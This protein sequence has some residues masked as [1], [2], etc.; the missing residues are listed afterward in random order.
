[1][2]RL[3]DCLK[4]AVKRGGL[5]KDEL[6]TFKEEALGTAIQ[7]I[8]SSGKELSDLDKQNIVT[9]AN[10]S[11]ATQFIDNQ[12]SELI[13]INEVINTKPEVA[14]KLEQAKA[15]R[16]KNEQEQ[17]AKAEEKQKQKAGDRR[18]EVIQIRLAKLS[19]IKNPTEKEQKEIVDL[20]NEYLDAIKKKPSTSEIGTKKVNTEVSEEEEYEEDYEDWKVTPNLKPNT[21]GLEVEESLADLEQFTKDL[22]S[23]IKETTAPKLPSDK[24]FNEMFETEV[25]DKDGAKA[26][27]LSTQIFKINTLFSKN[28]YAAFL[29]RLKRKDTVDNRLAFR[30]HMMKYITALKEGKA[31]EFIRLDYAPQSE[32]R[33]PRFPGR[34][35]HKTTMYGAGKVFVANIIG[36]VGHY[37]NLSRKQRE[38]LTQIREAS[39][40]EGTKPP[41]SFA[42]YVA[43]QLKFTGVE[44]KDLDSAD[45]AKLSREYKKLQRDYRKTATQLP[46]IS[47][48]KLS[49]AEQAVEDARSKIIRLVKAGKLKQSQVK[50]AMAKQIYNNVKARAEKTSLEFEEGY[51]ESQLKQAQEYYKNSEEIIYVGKKELENKTFSEMT[52]KEQDAY[53]HYKMLEEGSENLPAGA[54]Y[55]NSGFITRSNGTERLASTPF[56]DK[57]R[58]A[59]MPKESQFTSDRLGPYVYAALASKGLIKAVKIN[60]IERWVPTEYGAEGILNIKDRISMKPETSQ[61]SAP[62][63][64]KGTSTKKK[65]K[66]NKQA[67]N[68]SKKIK[69]VLEDW[70]KQKGDKFVKSAH[71]DRPFGNQGAATRA[72]NQLAESDKFEVVKFTNGHVVRLKEI[73]T[74]T[75][76]ADETEILVQRVNE[77]L[78]I[79]YDEYQKNY[80]VIDETEATE[81]LTSGLEGKKLTKQQIADI[82]AFKKNHPDV[83]LSTFK[84]KK[85]GGFYFDG[86]IYLIKENLKTEADVIAVFLHEGG[87]LLV[88]KDPRFRVLYAQI[89]K[90]FHKK[91]KTDPTLKRIYAEVK[92]VYLQEDWVEETIMHYVQ[93]QAN[94]NKP[95]Y[96]ELISKL[97]VWIAIRFNKAIK[98]DG[99]DLG[100]IIRYHIQ[101]RMNKKVA[102]SKVR[103]EV[104]DPAI[105]NM[106]TA[107]EGTNKEKKMLQ[108]ARVAAK[109][110]KDP[111]TQVGAVI[112]DEDGK[113]ISSGINVLPK[114]MDSKIYK[115]KETKYEHIIHSEV[116]AISKAL[117]SGK[118]LVGST[119]SVYPLPP[120]QKCM[121]RIADAGISKVIVQI[122]ENSAALK[123]WQRSIMEAMSIA[124]KNNIE[125]VTL[126]EL[127]AKDVITAEMAKMTF[128]GVNTQNPTAI[129]SLATAKQMGKDGK[130]QRYI[131][132]NTGWF[133]GPQD[134]MPRFEINDD[135][136]EVKQT[137]GITSVADF[138]QHDE[139]FASYPWIKDI[140]LDFVINPDIDKR[141]TYGLT[142]PNFKDAKKG[143][144]AGNY[145]FDIEIEAPNINEAVTA[146]LHE[147]QHTIQLE[148]GFGRGGVRERETL[149]TP[150]ERRLSSG[151]VKTIREAKALVRQKTR[152]LKPKLSQEDYAQVLSA[153]ELAQLGVAQ[154]IMAKFDNPT[155]LYNR[156]KKLVG[157]IEAEDVEARYKNAAKGMPALQ[158]PSLVSYLSYDYA[159]RTVLKKT[160]LKEVKFSMADSFKSVIDSFI[161]SK[162]PAKANAAKLINDI[163]YPNI[164]KDRQTTSNV[165]RIFSSSEHVLVKDETSERVLE[166]ALNEESVRHEKQ[167]YILGDYL[168][169][170]RGIEHKLGRRFWTSVTGKNKS[171]QKFMKALEEKV[172]EY[173]V[174]V[175]ATGKGWRVKA[176]QEK[177]AMDDIELDG[178][179]PDRKVTHYVVIKPNGKQVARKFTDKKVAL[180]VAHGLEY[181]YLIKQGYSKDAALWIKKSRELTDRAFTVLI[182]DLERGIKDAKLHGI[183]PNRRIESKDGKIKSISLTQAAIEMG[184]LQGTYFPRERP[185]KEY[186]VV[187]TKGK[188][189]EP[190][191]KQDRKN[192]S[193]FYTTND[194]SF[195]VTNWA[196]EQLR[197]ATPAAIYARKMRVAGWTTE[198]EII[199]TPTDMIFDMPKL[200]ASMSTILGKAA[201]E[202]GKVTK[203][204]TN[205]A[206]QNMFDQITTNINQLFATRS[207]MAT[208]AARQK[209]LWTGYETEANK[210]LLSY[211]QRTAAAEA[212]KIT[213]RSMVLAFTGRDKSFNKWAETQVP[214][215]ATEENYRAFAQDRAI[216]PVKQKKLWEDTQTFISH[217]LKPNNTTANVIGVFKTLAVLKYLGWRVS[218]PAV[219]MTNM[220]TGVIGTMSAKTDIG[221]INSWKLV[222]HAADTYFRYRLELMQKTGKAKR[223]PST[224]VTTEE[225][226]VYDYVSSK[227]WDSPLYN[228]E[229]AAAMDNMGGKIFNS[230]IKHAMWMFGQSEKAN[231]AMTIKASFDA[232]RRSKADTYTRMNKA[233]SNSKTPE[234]KQDAFEKI[235][236]EAKRISDNAHGS[237]GKASKPWLIQ[238]YK[239]LDVPYTF[240][241]FTHNYM[242]NMYN[243]GFNDKQ[244]KEAVYLMMAP[245]FLAGAGAT[246]ALPAVNALNWML[247]GMWDDPEE[248]FYKF[249]EDTIGSDTIA[250][251]GIIGAT[252]GISFKGSLQAN[253]PKWEK[254]I[255]LLGAPGSLAVDFS[256]AWDHFRH[257]EYRKGF[258]KALPSAAGN[259]VRGRREQLEGQTLKGYGPKFFGKEQIG[260]T[261]FELL[262]RYMSL[263]PVRLQKISEVQWSDKQIKAKYLKMRNSMLRKYKHYHVLPY[264]KRS[265][266][267]LIKLENERNHY[268]ELVNTLDPKTLIPYAT[269]P[270]LKRQLKTAFK[271]SK[272]E[273]NR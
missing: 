93:D 195:G 152:T 153:T 63:K 217:F 88:D 46:V 72:L 86:K 225:R 30:T 115:T 36:K 106:M 159:Q 220:V 173:L 200:L 163:V 160:N 190:G 183:S 182:A 97:K 189:G 116:T 39:L 81:I 237:Y 239:L 273:R 103:T 204:D 268:N 179:K 84:G 24:E 118:N 109:K 259:M 184:N 135:N 57:Q 214:E 66:A 13:K 207:T 187:S 186:S 175:D 238:K 140:P 25:E 232:I 154:E 248:E 105:I 260:I 52:D 137:A 125:I 224:K 110:S 10:I 104:T 168:D 176:I 87:H 180:K 199:K 250:R 169:H 211:A 132:T 194:K 263:A 5:S 98:L 75:V 149:L 58:I 252:T 136:L 145:T 256:D 113:I 264:N 230:T 138:M 191:F 82:A 253:L 120:C 245:G 31:P 112:V 23:N 14:S 126:K 38:A 48:R 241:K 3:D 130:S 50:K 226:K 141:D 61:K 20:E 267:Y 218:S 117:K 251:Y 102:S 74:E 37:V 177:K 17:I 33:D 212:R 51:F 8:K 90:S 26:L 34:S 171:I 185:K 27:D 107:V 127:G 139:L 228:F 69:I 170:Q 119:L 178:M 258:E 164:T 167:E 29:K 223:T 146:L 41:S 221:I 9:Q 202:G 1:M 203:E 213:A 210:A 78:G 144:A 165:E 43:E 131:Q 99:Y 133:I 85:V 28:T 89:L 254:S 101:R 123:R 53:L 71:G 6:A 15:L 35:S 111:S 266:E 16:L 249:V 12:A 94:V 162:D 73:K 95:W 161:S 83:N 206:M 56:P 255:D 188:K 229:A 235:M 156:Y 155:W 158:D 60:G 216:D 222:G 121:Q 181:N 18:L 91:I 247:G 272:F 65:T 227:G 40:P 77:Q 236:R 148:E 129:A 49:F 262:L 22:A 67:K 47:W 55:D 96:K 150:E 219:N 240:M 257:D 269:D 198:V 147:L 142:Q 196:K 42:E 59:E 4:I 7:N 80:Q 265:P 79:P 244:V 151:A 44:H 19:K 21:E 270:W 192:F 54:T 62:N 124:K 172:S 114:G 70:T 2:T 64:K 32:K 92:E 157:E 174:K 242:L 209:T 201:K 166:P 76:V 197:K 134:K 100:K 243:V 246:I 261:K 68:K 205:K 208:R 45:K 233:Y 122:P 234:G 271:P 11:I 193:Y 128:G 231:R 108:L 143:Y 215:E